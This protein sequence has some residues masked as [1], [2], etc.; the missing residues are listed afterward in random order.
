MSDSLDQ[1]PAHPADTGSTRAAKPTTTRALLLGL[2]L[3]VVNTYW[4]GLIEVRWGISYGS[5]LPIFVTPVFLLFTLTGANSVV[6]R[7][8]PRLALS[9]AELLTTYIMVAISET[10]MGL[11]FVQNLFGVIGHP[12][13]FATTGNQWAEL[14][15]QY[16]P[17][18]LTVSDEKALAALYEGG[19]SL[20]TPGVLRPFLVPLAGWGIMLTALTG[21]MLCLNIL[22]REA[23]I[24]H[25]RLSYPMAVL[26][27]AM[28]KG[29][30]ST[31]RFFADKMMWIGFGLA[32]L[33]YLINGIHTLY[34]AVPAVPGIKPTMINFA[35]PP[36][37]AL[38][39]FFV[40]V[41][42]FAIAFAFFIPSDLSFSC[43]FLYL[44]GQA[45][46]VLAQVFG[47][48]GP[49]PQG[50]PYLGNQAAG[51]WLAMTVGVL[52]AARKHFAHV[53]ELLWRPP[54]DANRAEVSLYRGAVVGMV[55]CLVALVTFFSLAGMGFSLSVGFLIIFYVISIAIT[56]VRAQFGTPHE[57]YFVNPH[58]ILVDIAGAPAIGRP[59]LTAMS[60]TY[61]FN[62]GYECHPMPFQLE[63]MKMAD[64]AGIDL[65]ALLKTIIFATLISIP[66]SYW[67]NLLFLFR[68][69]AA[70][71]CSFGGR[72]A[73]VETFSR[74]AQWLQTMPERNYA[75]I[76][77]MLAGLLIFSG[78]RSVHLRTSLPLHP[79]GYA[80]A[81]SYAMQTFWPSFLVGWLIKVV[82][83]R[84]GGRKAHGY[85]FRFFV[86]LLLGDYVSASLWFIIGPI[87]QVVTYKNF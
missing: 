85:A 28:T 59:Q 68:D 1:A 43:W 14:F 77:A 47:V 80:L 2:V 58:R 61:W 37:T 55:I 86:G 33:I 70:A 60:T 76:F 75:A 29:R 73:G 50:F 12:Y 21:V 31:V 4:V 34:P 26:P 38:W 44:F 66:L 11:D 81:T 39:W 57:Q 65:R 19:A 79:I 6:K 52:F 32:A 35:N 48:L 41:Y 84:Y 72:S 24:K 7:I 54:Q 13:W 74:L 8:H 5:C 23:W 83:L 62:R 87:M 25:D 16:L 78:L 9:P 71:K 27:L 20:Q 10:L 49:Q 56:R 67:A 17:S 36:W 22:L 69:G 53:W 18:W 45:Q 3:M 42:P 30:P 46:R 63:S 82:V 40:G 51:A 64:S 15:H